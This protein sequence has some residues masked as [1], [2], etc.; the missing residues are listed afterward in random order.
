M[1]FLYLPL[2]FGAVLIL[3]SAAVPAI[4]SDR[5]AYGFDLPLVIVIH[6][7]MVR[8]KTPGMLAGL[9]LGYLQ[10]AMGGGALGF[11]GISKII[12]GFM[13]G[14]LKEKF[15]IRNVVHRTASIAG[16]VFMALLAKI[17]T[18]ALFG[19]PG[20]DLLSSQFFWGLAGNTLLA[21]AAHALLE[22][23]ETLFGIRVEEELSL[24]D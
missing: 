18:Y 24:G 21:L 5:F 14:Y 9:V 23:F 17:G 16:A 6:V 2:L 22:R 1:R 4:L 8:G 7:A 15:F 12:A 10:D 11:N 13:G 20:P 3:Q 19:Q